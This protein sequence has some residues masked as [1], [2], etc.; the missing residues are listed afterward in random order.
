MKY[1]EIITD[2]FKKRGWS[3]GWVAM[4]RND[5]DLVESPVGQCLTHQIPIDKQARCFLGSDSS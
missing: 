3:L 5:T 1:W 4:N 2:D